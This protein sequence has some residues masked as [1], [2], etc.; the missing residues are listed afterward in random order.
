MNLA[1][2]LPNGFMFGK[3]PGDMSIMMLPLASRIV[4]V[5]ARICKARKNGVLV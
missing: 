3:I 5:D 2:E 1:N 4:S